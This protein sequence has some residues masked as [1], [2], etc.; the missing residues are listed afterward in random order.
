[1]A[2]G[3]EK[4]RRAQLSV[5]LVML[6]QGAWCEELPGQAGYRQAFFE[7][8]LASLP[9]V[10]ASSPELAAA[11]TEQREAAIAQMA[12]GYTECHM[13]AMAMYSPSIQEAAYSV[14]ASGGSYPEAMYSLNLAIGTEGAAGGAREAAVKVMYERAAKVGQDCIQRV[15][16]SNALEGQ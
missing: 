3:E 1:M 7:N 5:V 8:I 10:L 14:I 13:E 9:R 16:D 11:T 6:A 15:Q 12:K 2:C 4:M